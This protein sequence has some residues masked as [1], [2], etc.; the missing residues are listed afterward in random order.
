MDSELTQIPGTTWVTRGPAEIWPARPADRR[1]VLSL[2]AIG[3]ILHAAIDGLLQHRLRAALS[4]L[5]ISWG[6]VSVVMLLA[7]GSGFHRALVAGFQGAFG[8]GVVVASP[9]QTSMQ[10]GG[11]RAGRAVNVTAD[12]VLALASLPLVRAVSPEFVK[13]MSIAHDERTA[14]YTVRGVSAEYG[15]MR[16][17][18]PASG[19]RFLSS[20]DVRLHRRVAF[21]GG[22]IQ[23]KLFGTMPPEGMSIRIN[24]QPFEVVG[25]LADKVQ[26][27]TY[28]APDEQSIFIPYTTMGQLTDTRDVSTFVF[29]AMA[30]LLESRA[31]SEV[32][33]WLAKRYRY[34][35]ADRRALV[36][37][38]AEESLKTVSGI[39]E[40]LRLVLGF[41]GVL[42]LLIGGVGIMNIM[43][44]S[45]TERTRE[46][47]LRKALG[48]RRS[49]I[50]LQFLLEGLAT[51]FAGGIVGV[52]VSYVLVWIFSP[53]PFLS[54]LLDDRSRITDIHLVLS[55][56]LLALCAGI[57]IIVGLVSG[58]LPAW[59]ASRMDPIES[60]RYE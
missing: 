51:T 32:R 45:V 7:Y 2:H 9:G 34:D 27:S 5:G 23:R 42:T 30:P 3:E 13:R 35:P 18:K 60:L 19:G 54:E 49:E 10:A 28:F 25:V 29:Q 8:A 31:T 48:A 58:F 43:F 24:G 57:L 12:D 15:P 17:E 56:E 38:G 55:F 39:T 59:R 52:I 21:I 53:R 41:I 4:M 40:G 22:D 33:T 16:S 6:I 20:D 14:T 26:L 47:G 44:V 37:G 46:I 1:R 50:L 11:E 36:T